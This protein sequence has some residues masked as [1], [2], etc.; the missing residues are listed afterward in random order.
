MKHYKNKMMMMGDSYSRSRQL[1]G[2]LKK[3]GMWKGDSC[4]WPEKVVEIWKRGSEKD[5]GMV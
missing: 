1:Q 2:N 5:D 4:F 3:D